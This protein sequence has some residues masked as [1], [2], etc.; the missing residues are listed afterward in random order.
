MIALD[1]ILTENWNIAGS[2]SQEDTLSRMFVALIER[3]SS[4]KS[5]SQK[6][7]WTLA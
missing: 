2:F 5:P 1:N 7:F 3:I 4:S 6:Y